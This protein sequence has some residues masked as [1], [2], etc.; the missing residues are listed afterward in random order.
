MIKLV[1]FD[2]R[3]PFKADRS[4]LFTPRGQAT[5]G[6]EPLAIT[7]GAGLDTPWDVGVK[8]KGR[9]ANTDDSDAEF[10]LLAEAAVEVAGKGRPMKGAEVEA[11][12]SLE[13]GVARGVDAA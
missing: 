1:S 9:P 7:G 12:V 11:N 10:A 5:L 13:A 2:V 3:K 8:G 4:G 6:A